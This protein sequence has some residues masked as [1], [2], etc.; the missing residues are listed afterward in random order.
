MLLPV[1]NETAAS[2]ALSLM[3]EASC[4]MGVWRVLKVGLCQ[5]LI[6]AF[7]KHSSFKQPAFKPVTLPRPV[8]S[9]VSR[10]SFSPNRGQ[11]YLGHTT[12]KSH[13]KTRHAGQTYAVRRP[14]QDL[15]HRLAALALEPELEPRSSR[16]GLYRPCWP[17]QPALGLRPGR[18][19][20][21]LFPL[22]R[23][24]RAVEEA[25]SV[26][27]G[28]ELRLW[29]WSVDILKYFLGMP[30]PKLPAGT[31]VFS[32]MKTRNKRWSRDAPAGPAG[33]AQAPQ[34]R[35]VSST[36]SVESAW[37]ASFFSDLR[38]HSFSISK[39]ATSR[40]LE[41]DCGK[42]GNEGAE[43]ENKASGF[44][45]RR[46]KPV[47]TSEPEPEGNLAKSDHR[48]PGKAKTTLVARPAWRAGGGLGLQRSDHGPGA[49]LS[50]Q[51][52]GLQQG[53]RLARVS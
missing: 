48:A 25:S 8:N 27:C 19:A 20:H 3:Q 30:S 16:Q 15:G 26:A 10:V 29:L 5:D 32:K 28:F 49:G 4:L 9:K 47:L 45:V 11:I 24:G 51:G 13:T 50:E 41:R 42:D 18:L 36:G 53:A 34:V 39:L 35:M 14:T 33:G 52:P 1:L 21:E 43:S 46:Q 38:L 37:L 31:S 22:W 12:Q 6:K 40:I 7:I 23:G 17:G 2:L 44:S